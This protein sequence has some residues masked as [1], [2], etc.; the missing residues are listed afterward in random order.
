MEPALGAGLLVEWGVATLAF[1]G[2]STSGDQYLVQPFEHGVLIA[3]V[4]G[5]GHGQEAAAAAR[6]AII[7][8]AA[9]PHCPV[10]ELVRQCDRAL[11]QTRGAVITLAALYEIKDRM[12]W[13]GIGNVAGVLLRVDPQ[14]NPAHESLLLRGGIVG[15]KLP[16]LIATNHQIQPGDMLIFATDGIDP[17]FT[18]SLWPDPSPQ[19]LATQIL[20]RYGKNTD[21]ALA[22]VVRWIGKRKTV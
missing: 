22:L 8:L 20:S 21:D 15:Y 10:V 14:A 11:R 18:R 2:Q 5:L 4:D 9:C 7:T 1:G 17:E 13:M 6:A 3:V 16:T 19:H 12:T